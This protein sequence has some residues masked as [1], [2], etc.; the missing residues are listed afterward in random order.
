MPRNVDQARSA[1]CAH[2]TRDEGSNFQDERSRNRW[3]KHFQ[4]P[5]MSSHILP[6]TR[7]LDPMSPRSAFEPLP[8]GQE[9]AIAARWA[10][11]TPWVC[12]DLRRRGRDGGISS[13]EFL[14]LRQLHSG[15]ILAMLRSGISMRTIRRHRLDDPRLANE[16]RAVLVAA[17]RER[18][19]KA[20]FRRSEEQRKQDMLATLITLGPA[21]NL[22]A[23]KGPDSESHK[24]GFHQG[25]VV[26]D[27]LAVPAAIQTIRRQVCEHFYLREMRDPE[28]TVRSN[29]RAYVLP[30]QLAMY[31][32]RQL[33]GATLE[34]IGREFGGR[35]HST[36]LHSIGKIEE[37]RC[38]DEALNCA[39]TRLM[40]AVVAKF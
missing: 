18:Q 39:I 38:S 20:R 36:V 30:R 13:P 23:T 34:E 25:N 12:M 28:F 37:M 40:E 31:V 19:S 27:S 6:T 24:R 8:P 16:V 10:K 7:T 33:M 22:A 2:V 21:A 14:R 32:A 4:V 26:L 35:H 29:R 3:Y 11:W 17:A 1:S 9:R 15:H 5:R